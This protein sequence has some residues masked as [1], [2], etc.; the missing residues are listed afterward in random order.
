MPQNKKNKGGRPKKSD[1]ETRDYVVSTRLTFDQHNDYI[2]A[3]STAG[4]TTSGG[5][6]LA[7]ITGGDLTPGKIKNRVNQNIYVE[8]T[9]ILNNTVQAIEQ[10]PSQEDQLARIKHLL[11]YCRENAFDS[12]IGHED[13]ITLGQFG[14]N[15]NAAVRLAHQSKIEIDP[16]LL[17]GLESHLLSVRG[18][19]NDC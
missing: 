11:E 1:D 13:F 16:V 18:L 9:R 5:Y 19:S 3:I 4:Y 2:A 14:T 12:V 10:C 6:L 8:V 7:L 15:V 17:D